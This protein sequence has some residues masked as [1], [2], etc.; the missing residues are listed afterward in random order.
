M[1]KVYILKNYESDT[2][3]WGVFSTFNNAREY[4]VNY[5]KKFYTKDDGK[6]QEKSFKDGHYKIILT[7][8]F[9]G[10]L[11][12]FKDEHEFWI[13]EYDVDETLI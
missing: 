1:K 10:R 9:E 6:W 13:E 2:E 3:I 4:L 12:G 8:R 5:S 7:E 11:E